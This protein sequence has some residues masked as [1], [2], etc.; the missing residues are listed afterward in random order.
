MGVDARLLGDRLTGVGRYVS[1][2]CRELAVLLP[3]AEFLLYA[4][5]PIRMPVSSSRWKMRIDPLA[6]ILAGMRGLWMTK[7]A[8]MLLRVGA[9]AARDRVNLFWVADFPFVPR[10]AREVP[11]VATV[12]DFRHRMTPGKMRRA[13]L[14]GRKVLERRAWRVDEFVANSSGT[15]A[16]L[17]RFLGRDAAVIARPAVS[18]CFTRRSEAE[19]S[20]MCRRLGI[21]R[22]YLLALSSM[23]PHKNIETLISVFAEMVE[24]GSLR[25]HRLVLAGKGSE[26]MIGKTRLAHERLGERIKGLGFVRD[27]DLP[28]LYS[29]ADLFVLPSLDEGF[30]IPVLE[31]RACLTRVVAS[32]LPELREA[33][34]DHAI[35]IAPTHKGIREGILRGLSM[36]A[37]TGPG[38]LWT[39]RSSAEPIARLFVDSVERAGRMKAAI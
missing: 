39:W 16:K 22:P 11:I 1:E 20:E 3:E 36:A 18:S 24:R 12:H 38:Q 30:G 15:A 6:G 33:G 37:P 4:P 25:D 34:G 8:W 13:A 9:L 28:A 2:L 27:D 5:W 31:A 23:D 21:S 17:R 32:D 35:Y 14:Y 10:I 29:G 19:I 7:H 26:E